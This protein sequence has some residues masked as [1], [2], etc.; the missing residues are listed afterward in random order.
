[1]PGRSLAALFLL[2]AAVALSGCG[3]SGTS[4]STSSAGTPTTVA[5]ASPADSIRSRLDAAGFAVEE[6]AGASGNPALQA[7]LDVSLGAAKVT[8]YVYAS[9]TDAAK[10]RGEF[11]PIERQKPKQI[12]V[13]RVGRTVYVGTIEE[14]ASLPMG[15]F[16]RVVAVGGGA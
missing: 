9:D 13:R 2:S 16:N 6:G 10:V 11:R 1:M 4:E 15:K 14:P 5:S 7:E 3:G 12:E 8:I